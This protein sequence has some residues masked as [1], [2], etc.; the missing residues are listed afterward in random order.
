MRS[1]SNSLT[2]L[3]RQQFASWLVGSLLPAQTDADTLQSVQSIHASQLYRGEFY[4]TEKNWKINIKIEIFFTNHEAKLN[5]PFCIN[6]K[7]IIHISH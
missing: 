4:S 6:L 7:Y 1:H 5:K 2:S 3:V